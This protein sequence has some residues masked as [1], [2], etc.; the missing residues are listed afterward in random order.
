LEIRIPKEHPLYMEDINYPEPSVLVC[1]K[2]GKQAAYG[3]ADHY[4]Q[5]LTHRMKTSFHYGSDHDEEM[6]SFEVC[7]NCLLNWISS[8]EYHPKG[9]DSDGHQQNE[10]E[11]KLFKEWKKRKHTVSEITG[12]IHAADFMGLENQAVSLVSIKDEEDIA[13]K[14]LFSFA[15]DEGLIYF[16]FL[17]SPYIERQSLLFDVEC[18]EIIDQLNV[19]F[20]VIE[21]ERLNRFIEMYNGVL[22][23]IYSV[24]K[25]K[26]LCVMQN[27]P[28]YRLANLYQ[29]IEVSGN[30]DV[31]L[32]L[33]K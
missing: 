4:A 5:N 6:W 9:F 26:I 32:F 11:E 27:H 19:S 20:R 21:E 8:F 18:Y 33:K 29:E 10:N 23:E 2:C 30:H 31:D 12:S 24:L 3:F 25:E 22:N 13:K 1:D 17:V 28:L 14:Y 16:G 7:E 15:F